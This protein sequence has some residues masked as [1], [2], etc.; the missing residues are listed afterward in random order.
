VG[1]ITP[2][3]MQ[4]SLEASI[5]AAWIATGPLFLGVRKGDRVGGAL[6]SGTRPAS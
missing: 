3:A 5:A 4:S 1:A 2:D 6:E